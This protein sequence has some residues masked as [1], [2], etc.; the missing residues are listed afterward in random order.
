MA[1]R[2]I[3]WVSPE[4]YLDQEA[5]SDTKHSYYAG[6][7]LAMAGGLYTHGRLAGNLLAELYAA[8]RGRGCGVIGSDVL[9]Q[10]GRKELYTYPDVMVICGAVETMPGRPSVVT[11][12]VFV[13]EVLS[14]STVAFDRGEKAAEYRL[15][16][17]V[18]AYALL[19]ADR[20]WVELYTRG[21]DGNW[22]LTDFKGLDG[23][24]VL[25]GLQCRVPMAALY[26]GVLEIPEN[27]TQS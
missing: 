23:D 10:T 26:D 8:L 15:S 5:L 14:P 4:E 16:S 27:L 20:P 21:G 11:N 6:T 24:L 7:V 25:E 12:P 1:A 19:W 2:H 22:K 17:T 13:A 18:Q 9:F 3:P